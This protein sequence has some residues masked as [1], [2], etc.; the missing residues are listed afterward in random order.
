[1]RTFNYSD[2]KSSKFWKI[3]LEGS[4]Y[5]V[6]FG[7]I[8]TEGQT[9]TKDFPSPQA[10]QKAHHKIIAEKLAEGD[11]EVTAPAP[12]AS[13]DNVL[14]RAL[15]DD[16]D[17]LAAHAAYADWL[18]EQGDP[19][20]EFIQIQL[21]LEDPDREAKGRKALQR[22]EKELLEAHAA[23]W[24]GGLADFLLGDEGIPFQF[25]RGWLDSIRVPEL[26]VAF[27]RALVRTPPTAPTSATWDCWTC[28]TID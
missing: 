16:P 14:E 21:A 4:S 17:D 24:L 2:D 3:E 9:K 1:M 25:A 28:R 11:V 18:G 5:T 8:G 6:R 13:T 20:G 26:S 22:R 19:R 12:A 7:R 15:L 23:E 27:A 10:A